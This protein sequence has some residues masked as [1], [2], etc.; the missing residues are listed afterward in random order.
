MTAAALASGF[1]AILAQA[2]LLN[3][4]RALFRGNEVVMG[5]LLFSWLCG[6][7][8]GARWAGR[9][10]DRGGRNAAVP[11]LLIATAGFL[12]AADVL[13][14]RAAF[15]YYR[16]RALPDLIG[17]TLVSF[18]AVA[19]MGCLS[20]VAF[21]VLLS[22]DGRPGRVYVLEALGAFAGG[23]AY[24][25][26][27]GGR[28]DSFVVAAAILCGGAA[29]ALAR[30][31]K[32]AARRVLL[33]GV[34]AA[35]A[36]G[37]WPRLRDLGLALQFRGSRVLYTH[38]SAYG[39]L[40]VVMEGSLR[41]SYLDGRLLPDLPPAS[42]EEEA[43][44]PAAFAGRPR[45]VLVLGYAPPLLLRELGA[46]GAEGIS[47]VFPG[48]EPH[49]EPLRTPH[50]ERF[51]ADPTRWAGVAPGS[52]DLVLVRAGLPEC[53]ADN[54]HLSV[55]FMRGLRGALAKGGVVAVSLPWE[56]EMPGGETVAGLRMV[57]DTMQEAFGNTAMV[58]GG[59]FHLAASPRPLPGGREALTRLLTRR[60]ARTVF[61]NAGFVDH[62]L[63]ADRMA[64]VGAALELSPAGGVNGVFSMGLYREWMKGW[65]R[66][67]MRE[68]RV[69][70]VFLLA[71]LLAL[72]LGYRH[73]VANAVFGDAR[74]AWLFAAG[75]SSMT[76][77]IQ[78]LQFHQGASG[79]AYR[80]FALVVGAYMLGVAAGGMLA[81]RLRGRSRRAAA[82]AAA[83]AG[84]YAGVTGVLYLFP[85]P[86]PVGLFYSTAAIA[87]L[88]LWGGTAAGGI[89]VIESIGEVNG[90]GQSRLYASD[91][92]G[93]ALAAL[94]SPALLVPLLGQAA[95]AGVS[96]AVLAVAW[97]AT[98]RAR[99]AV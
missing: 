43:L 99:L 29:V 47:V 84:V 11:G 80:A 63:S 4:L 42:A 78:L 12:L 6:S 14:I 76:A 82:Q 77:G 3:E 40:A 18:A 22:R 48:P 33:A 81:R 20:G 27:P 70:G 85:P 24:T 61:V 10:R 66:S 93:S 86:V 28:P 35:A 31:G 83:M 7:G 88:N 95:T 9:V 71:V 30:G 94:V 73:E 5:V 45:K 62:Y 98:R 38:A 41:S 55:E 49:G 34:V 51:E 15:G 89:F 8:A 90:P 19:P 59:T 13:G 50:V 69:V 44:V 72:G 53:I 16:L 17:I 64:R 23:L 92:F 57:R 37:A 36:I 65:I 39:K 60:R 46:A 2:V 26:F 58:P 79:F 74:A 96:C 25:L 68:N 1:A 91:L 97:A 54:R 75:F 56:E 87:A 67:D 21:P 52:Y 32:S